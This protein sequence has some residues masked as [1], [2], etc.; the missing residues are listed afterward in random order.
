MLFF[1]YPFV[2]DHDVENSETDNENE[3]R[4]QMPEGIHGQGTAFILNSY[5]NIHTRG[6]TE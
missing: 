1:K 4:A 6:Q 5:E 2:S 3:E